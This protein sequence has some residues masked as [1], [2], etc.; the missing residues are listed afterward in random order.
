MTI[1][2]PIAIC[3]SALLLSACGNKADLLMP[4]QVPPEDAGRYLIKSSVPTQQER[5]AVDDV[6]WDDAEDGDVDAT[7]ADDWGDDIDEGATDPPPVPVILDVP[8]GTPT[9]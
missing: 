6:E 4:A 9:P 8:A 2:L 5:D 3:L 7:D 1:R